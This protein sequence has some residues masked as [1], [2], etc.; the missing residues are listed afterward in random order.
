MAGPT[1]IVY[2][3]R[4]LEPAILD[5]IDAALEAI[6]A[7]LERTRKGRVWACW[8]D[9]RPVSVSVEA[10]GN[11]PRDYED[12]LLELGLLP[13]DAP[14]RVVLAA[15]CNDEPDYCILKSISDEISRIADGVVSATTK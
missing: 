9:G 1:S 12:E 14:F 15:R 2:S 10:F 3:R 6:S 7:P 13:E 4:K 11:G 5:A 8:I